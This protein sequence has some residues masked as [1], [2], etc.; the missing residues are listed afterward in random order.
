M[1]SS[2]E[3]NVCLFWKYLCLEFTYIFIYCEKELD[4]FSQFVTFIMIGLTVQTVNV[5]LGEINLPIH[6]LEQLNFLFRICLECFHYYSAMA[7]L[8]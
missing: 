3:N 8:I 4:Y 5:L 2:K 7:D 1:I 6:Q